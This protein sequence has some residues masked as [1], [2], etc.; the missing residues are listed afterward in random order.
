MDAA[1]ARRL[2]TVQASPGSFGGGA[3]LVTGGGATMTYITFDSNSA[4]SGGGLAVTGCGVSISNCYFTG[5]NAVASGT[6][7]G[8]AIYCEHLLPPLPVG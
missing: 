3:I 4:D 1:D 2:P 8:G 5:N 7:R 6:G